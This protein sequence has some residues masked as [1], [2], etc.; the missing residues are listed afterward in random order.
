MTMAQIGA[1]WSRSLRG[2]ARTVLLSPISP[3]VF[4][5][6]VSMLRRVGVLRRPPRRQASKVEKIF[7]SHP[8]SSVGDMVLLLPL[9]EK[10]KEEWPEAEVDIVAGRGASELLEGV[11]GLHRVFI[12]ESHRSPKG[13]MGD[14]CR[15]VRHLRLYKRQIMPYDY[16]LAI[17]PRWGSILTADAA[18]LAYLTGATQRV[19]YSGSV[20]GGSRAIDALFTI[21]VTGGKH[22]H[23]TSRNL[24]LLD[25]AG[26]TRTSG[27]KELY[28]NRPIKALINLARQSNRQAWLDTV[29]DNGALPA[30]K[31]AI[32]SPGATAA[33][34]VWPLEPLAWSIREI[35]RETGLIFY[36]VGGRGDAALCAALAEHDPGFAY[37]VA[38]KTSLKQ[39]VGLLVDAEL[40]VGMDSGT[41][42]I[43]GALGVPTVVISPFPETC[44]DEHQNSPIRFR[45]CGPKVRVLQPRYAIPPC[46]PSC[47]FPGPHCIRQVEKEEVVAAALQMAHSLL[48]GGNDSVRSG[49][50]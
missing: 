50:E 12:C 21:A 45:P 1:N 28:V 5:A 34:R 49:R 7:I 16:D 17:A 35:H 27:T 39:L 8:Y 22:E 24:K 9:I 44:E 13:I 14:Y 20:D 29:G 6:V 47:S 15:L 11:I 37:S 23:E 43:A 33:F 38:G 19:G 2:L 31:F 46:S 32:V 41:A 42:H 30:R 48:S 4:V 26:L 36:V 10:I 3:G 18:N 25:R 40:F